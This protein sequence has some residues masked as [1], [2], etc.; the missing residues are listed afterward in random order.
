MKG[1]LKLSVK[2]LTRQKRRNAIL[3]L[4]IAFGFLVVTF[5]DGSY[6]TSSIYY[7]APKEEIYPINND[8]ITEEYI[9]KGVKH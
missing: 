8:P 2:N 6:L 1:T 5:I 9:Q 3:A 7:S 4:A